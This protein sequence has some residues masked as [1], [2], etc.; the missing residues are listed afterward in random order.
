MEKETA[1]QGNDII[2]VRQVQ[3]DDVT[4]NLTNY[5]MRLGI[6]N[7]L[8]DLSGAATPTYITGDFPIT[9]TLTNSTTRTMQISDTISQN[10]P[11]GGYFYEIQ[12]IDPNNNVATVEIGRFELLARVIE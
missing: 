7:T 8:E 9:S 11:V 5:Q 4:Q 1:Y 2:F 3:V 12:L 6:S 10:I